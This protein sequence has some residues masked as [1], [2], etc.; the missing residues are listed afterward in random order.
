MKISLVIPF[1]KTAPFIRLLLPLIAGILVQWYARCSLSS[2]MISC[3]FF[4]AAI[5][6]F[7]YLPLS[8]RYKFRKLQGLL[9]HGVIMSIALFIG[10]QKD[11]RHQLHWYGNAYRDSV[12]L[13]VTINE[14]PVQKARSLKA[15]AIVEQLISGD[16]MQTASGKMIL[17]FL[18][19][20]S[21]PVIA[22]GDRIIFSKPLQVIKNSGNPGAFDYR[23]YAGFQQLYH[24]VYLRK[25]DYRVL[26]KNNQPVFQQWLF[27][28]RDHIIFT[29]QKHLPEKGNVQG[30]AEALLIGYKADLDKDLVQAYS[31]AGV[32]HIIAISGLHLGLIYILLVWLLD[33][34][35]LIKRSKLLKVMLVLLFLWLFSL[36]TGASASVLRSAVM[37]TCIIIGKNYFRQ[38]S[39]YN[40]LAASAFLLLCYDPFFLWDVGFQL[41]Y[42]AVYGIV[43]LQKPIYHAWYI[44][45]KWLSKIWEM[46]AVTIAAQLITFPACLF[47]FHQFP[48]LFLLTNLVA[49]PLSTLILFIEIILVT[50]SR[51]PLLATI[52]ARLTEWLIQLMNYLITKSIAI[53]YSVTD[54]IFSTALTTYLLYGVVLLCCAGWLNK[55]KKLLMGSMICLVAMTA[56][57]SAADIAAQK[58]QKVIIYNVPKC[59]AIDLVQGMDYHF[60]GDSMLSKDGQLQN[61]HLKPGRVL[62]HLKNRMNN[63]RQASH[64]K[65][66]W[67]CGKSSILIVDSPLSFAPLEN[68]IPIDIL[69][70]SKNPRLKI[71][72]ITNAFRPSVVVFDGSNSLWKITQW[73]RECEQLLLRNFS[74]ADEG[75][76]ILDTTD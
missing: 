9:L 16:T 73:K 37:F 22:Y 41:S 5:A 39:I 54:N 19:D 43:W 50:F 67:Q 69:L 55:N 62:F 25:N 74:V 2:I 70:I 17:Y 27:A 48:N 13:I 30:I 58:Q 66:L 71:P 4:C 31:N 36:L 23:R 47:Y 46:A 61:F 24:T 29:L 60:I 1:W 52:T 14:P 8:V 49:V 45:N 20:S 44:K 28:A 10:R 68:R 42:L 56:V 75:A 15:E 63:W 21:A 34:A 38:A 35:P 40:S 76:F 11:G 12:S 59:Q 18:S 7:H 26:S 64:Y 6:V 32:V 57:Y 65:N 53:P 3:S 51:I 33:R 72:G